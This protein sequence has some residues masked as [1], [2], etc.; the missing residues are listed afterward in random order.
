MTD[1]P[2]AG[3]PLAEQQ[4]E[5]VAALVAGGPVPDGVDAARLEAAREALLRKR[6]GEVA[7][8]WPR[9]AAALGPRWAAEFAD[10]ARGRPPAGPDAD[11]LAFA[12][13]LDAA[14]RLP[15]GA[16]ADLRRAEITVRGRFNPVRWGHRLRRR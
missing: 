3:K 5:L 16:R 4:A 8:R 7:T 15:E 2:P 13:D 14:G 12:A 11:G 1:E 10:W 6:A 9:L